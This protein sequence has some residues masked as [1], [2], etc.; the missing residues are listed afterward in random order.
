MKYLDGSIYKSELDGLRGL[1]FIGVFLFHLGLVFVP[2]GFVGVDIFFVIS[3]YVMALTQKY[4]FQEGSFNLVTYLEQRARRLLPALFIMLLVVSVIG[5]SYISFP[6]DRLQLG[7]SLIS[8]VGFFS[9]F[10]FGSLDSYFNSALTDNLL[11]HTWTLSLEMQFYLLL[12][13]LLFLFL[14]NNKLLYAVALASFA[15]NIYLTIFIGNSIPSYGTF[16]FYFVGSRLWEFLAGMW[17][18]QSNFIV[19]KK[20]SE[21]MGV[22]GIILI[23]VSFLTITPNIAF[24][25]LAALVPVFGSV[26]LIAGAGNRTIVNSILNMRWLVYLGLC[27]YALYLW[28]WPLI[29]LSKIYWGNLSLE[30]IVLVTL[31]TLALG[32]LSF[33]TLENPIRT[34]K[35]L[36]TTTSFFGVMT[37]LAL[38][39]IFF[40]LLLIMSVPKQTESE[41]NY[42]ALCAN[43]VC[44]FGADADYEKTLFLWG[45]S[46]ALMFAPVLDEIAEIYNTRIVAVITPSCGIPLLRLG[47]VVETQPNRDDCNQSGQLAQTVLENYEID[48]VLLVARWSSYAQPWD[49]GDKQPVQLVEI[50][51]KLNEDQ[52]KKL[53]NRELEYTL[54]NLMDKKIPVYLFKSIPTLN[55]FNKRELLLATKN[56]TP[57]NISLSQYHQELQT[58]PSLFQKLDF[59]K[60]KE[61]DPET[62]LCDSDKCITKHNGK[63]LYRD[64]GHL[65]IDGLCLLLPLFYEVFDTQNLKKE[66]ALC[67]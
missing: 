17:L 7:T 19:S 45:D 27:S 33:H 35:I 66:I 62:L 59:Y 32:S 26:L 6:A 57:I 43:V 34:K 14:K 46:Y 13:F 3:G 42:R 16:G 11:L 29:V 37:V 51:A 36:K 22:A 30:T 60:V 12:P 8:Q 2:G 41:Q 44:T 20:M 24:P 9:N 5:Y 67:H 25:G 10:Y 49:D 31:T 18:V 21:Y 55:E 1:A 47:E 61:I 15:L 38:T 28:H 52:T 50:G 65:S 53:F 39:I 64:S 48:K 4:R 58:L 23:V 63:I 40:G 54:T 56:D